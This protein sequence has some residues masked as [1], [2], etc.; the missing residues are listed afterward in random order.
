MSHD[1]PRFDH[2]WSGIGNELF[3]LH[4]SWGQT[5]SFCFSFV[6]VCW[7]TYR[8]PCLVPLK[9]AGDFVVTGS[10][11]I[12]PPWRIDR[13]PVTGSAWNSQH[14][15]IWNKQFRD[16]QDSFLLVSIP[17]STFD[18]TIA[19]KHPMIRLATRHKWDSK[20]FLAGHYPHFVYIYIYIYIYTYI[21]RNL[22]IYL[23]IHVQMCIYIHCICMYVMLDAD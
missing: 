11:Q 16:C 7:V 2:H 10:S 18:A 14:I 9:N 1:V 6:A 17:I 20:L 8:C 15:H 22:Y 3:S 13:Q 21:H 5:S 4:H 12:S 19:I 23:Y